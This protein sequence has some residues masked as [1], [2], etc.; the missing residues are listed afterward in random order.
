M[1]GGR[2]EQTRT[3]RSRRAAS[4][5]D[6]RCTSHNPLHLRPPTGAAPRRAPAERPAWPSTW[7]TGPPLSSTQVMRESSASDSES[8][9]ASVGFDARSVDR[10]WI[11]MGGLR[12][13]K[14]SARPNIV[15][16][17]DEGERG[18]HK[19]SVRALP[20]GVQFR[21]FG[22]GSGASGLNI[23]HLHTPPPFR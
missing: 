3:R 4:H 8:T 11:E 18:R 16:N 9:L 17:T 7:W 5:G 15:T 2:P 1:H 21:P 10:M 20:R 14:P 12:S 13:C 22:F 19:K 6:W 23:F